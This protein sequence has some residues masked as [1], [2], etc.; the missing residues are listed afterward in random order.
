MIKTTNQNGVF[1]HTFLLTNQ[2]A[3]LYH[4]ICSFILECSVVMVTRPHDQDNQS[5]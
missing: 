1:G 3:V 4:L 2:N 5:E